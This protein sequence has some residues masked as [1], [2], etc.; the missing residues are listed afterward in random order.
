MHLDVVPIPDLAYDPPAPREPSEAS[1]A[2]LPHHTNDHK[3]PKLTP[4]RTL[5]L[6]VYEWLE[7]RKPSHSED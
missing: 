6:S 4:P 3:N 2:R 1:K 5:M 7:F